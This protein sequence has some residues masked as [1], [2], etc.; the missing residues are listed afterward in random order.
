MHIHTA[1]KYLTLFSGEKIFYREAGS[2]AAPTI[3]LLH[4][5]PTSSHQFR[6]LIPLLSPK[7]R[8]IAPDLPGFGFTEVPSSYNYT[9]DDIAT[10][11]ETFIKSV[12]QAPQQYTIYI[13][14][15]GAPTGLRIASKNPTAVSAIIT[16]N[17]NAYVE[18]LGPGWELI[19]RTWEN[20]TQEN[21]DAIR[22][23]LEFDATKAQY[24]NGTTDPNNIAPESYYLDQAL[25]DRPGNKDIQLDLFVDYKTNVELYPKFHEYFRASQVP[26]LAV[27]G[28]HDVFF[29]PEGAEAYKRDL[30]NAEVILLEAGH[31]AGETN[32]GQVGEIML[33]FLKRIGV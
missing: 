3:L 11:I 13:F 1:I 26:L 33:D 12:P 9:F 30:P 6:N 17:G 29:L 14:D 5:F 32:T 25:M 28:K 21:R 8:V 2:L 23:F 31:F 15:Y 19:K 18:G 10:T 22:P 27:W 16:Q 24:V 7:Y 20:D 4:G